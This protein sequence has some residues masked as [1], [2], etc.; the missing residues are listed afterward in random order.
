MSPSSDSLWFLTKIILQYGTSD[1]NRLSF[2]G[3]SNLLKLGVW[4]A[5]L[6]CLL[7]Y[8]TIYSSGT[9]NY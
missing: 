4:T 8:N 9:A 2:T 5:R 7:H 6:V 3:I 1:K